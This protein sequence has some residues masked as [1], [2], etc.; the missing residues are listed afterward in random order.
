MQCVSRL[1]NACSCSGSEPGKVLRAQLCCKTL[2]TSK[3]FFNTFAKSS[4]FIQRKKKAFSSRKD[5]DDSE[6]T[7]MLPD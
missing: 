3:P 2:Q 7:V 4:F 6:Q 1:L 5:E